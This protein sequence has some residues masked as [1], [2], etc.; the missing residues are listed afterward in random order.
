MD[1]KT[2][3]AQNRLMSRAERALPQEMMTTG[4]IH[5]SA[6]AT[7]RALA[8]YLK[9]CNKIIKYSAHIMVQAVNIHPVKMSQK[10]KNLRAAIIYRVF[11][12]FIPNEFVCVCYLSHRGPVYPG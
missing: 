12:R 1:N 10:K 6:R 9:D 7:A 2:E 5:F 11:S 3:S 4:Q 8:I